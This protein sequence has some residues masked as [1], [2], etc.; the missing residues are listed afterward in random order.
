MTSAEPAFI[1][2]SLHPELYLNVTGAS[3]ANGAKLIVW[4]KVSEP[5]QTFFPAFPTLTA[6][7]SNLHLAARSLE[8]GSQV[9]QSSFSQAWIYDP[10]T[11]SITAEGT[12]LVLD[13][14]GGQFI[15]GTF[16]VLSPR[17]TAHSAKWRI[18][19]VSNIV[20]APQTSTVFTIAQARDF[21]IVASVE[22]LSQA[23]GAAIVLQ[24]VTGFSHQ[25]WRMDGGSIRS[26]H[27]GLFLASEES[28]DVVQAESGGAWDLEVDGMI[29]LR[30]SGRVLDVGE[31]ERLVVKV[32]SGAPTQ[33]WSVWDIAR[34]VAI[35][36]PPQYFV[37][38]TDQLVLAAGAKDVALVKKTGG[39]D[40]QWR[41]E[42]GRVL[43]NL[44]SGRFLEVSGAVVKGAKLTTGTGR[45]TR[46]WLFEPDGAIRVK[47]FTWVIKAA[48]E[49][50][51][52]GLALGEPGHGG[53]QKW[54]LL[55]AA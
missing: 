18:V 47:G 21:G 38:V 53:L 23:P 54:V 26:A 43:R 8:P 1:I 52:A 4:R 37:H 34:G 27:S 29:A 35:N 39:W 55:R 11:E 40:Q 22:G 14:E 32:P 7:H 33:Y 30:G 25:H 36:G 41:V 31:G 17:R 6:L 42:G 15:P 48:G 9:I 24:P 2:S 45:F 16:V 20:T 46:Q 49:K 44:K 10:V 5:N 28:Q 51:G 13:I 12:D 19:N 50:I 3:T